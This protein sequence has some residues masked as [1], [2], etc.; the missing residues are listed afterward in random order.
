MYYIEIEKEQ[1]PY[2]TEIIINGQIFKLKFDYNLYDEKIYCSLYDQDDNILVEDDPIIM[3][4]ML[5][6]RLYIDSAGNMR[7]NFPKALIVPNFYESSKKSTITFKNID[8]CALFV[9]ELT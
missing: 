1:I 7:N 5:F 6:S 3:G 9:E 8:E 4:Q 2:T